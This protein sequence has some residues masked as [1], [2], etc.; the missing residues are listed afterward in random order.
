VIFTWLLSF[1]ASVQLS[2]LRCCDNITFKWSY[3]S[4]PT[5]YG[6]IVFRHGASIWSYLTLGTARILH[7]ER[8]G[9][10]TLLS[11]RPSPLIV[12]PTRLWT[13]KGQTRNE[14]L[15]GRKLFMGYFCQIDCSR[16]GRMQL[17]LVTRQQFA[18]NSRIPQKWW[19]LRRVN[20]IDWQL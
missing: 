16:R 20:E 5:Q 13:C 11:Q 14:C 9:L 3:C 15:H 4:V 10:H 1:C 2:C 8:V 6:P 12:R 19:N 18:L 7:W 17:A